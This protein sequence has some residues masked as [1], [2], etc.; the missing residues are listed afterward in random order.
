MLPVEQAVAHYLHKAGKGVARITGESAS[1]SA[2]ITRM[3]AIQGIK[4]IGGPNE[5]VERAL[6]L[7]TDTI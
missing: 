4:M 1:V 3:L 6:H 5:A 7:L 2:T